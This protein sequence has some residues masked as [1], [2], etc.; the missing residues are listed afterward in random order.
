MKDMSELSYILD[1]SV[2]QDKNCLFLH[3]KHYIEAI[4]QRYGMDKANPIA[5]PADTNMK[6][7]KNDGVSKPVDP[8]T[9]QSMVGSLLYAAMATRPDIAQ[10]V[11]VV[12]K[13]NAS[14]NAAHLT[15]VKRILCYLKG[16][17]NLTLAQYERSDSGT[18][19]GF[20]DADWGGDQD[21][22]RSTTGNVFLLGGGAVSWLS[23]KQATVA[24]STA[25][26]E[27]VALSQ[28]AQECTWLTR[29]LSVLG[30]DATPVVILEDNQGAIAIGKNPVDHSRTKHIDIRYHYI[31][32]C[33]QKGQIQLQYCPTDDMKADILTKPLAKQ[34]FE[35]L[36]RE[37]GLC[38]V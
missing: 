27:Y 17:L 14:P 38:N 23:K 21:D 29:L 2:I 24:L 4:L 9:Y 33:V 8:C 7:K 16:T 22:R 20:S 15:A 13:F 3:Q 30:M 28:A 10:A 12:S 5:T 1:I 25:E 36:R 32:E 6:L 19:V 37:I 31:R 26:A 18:L 34:K 11:S 35:Y